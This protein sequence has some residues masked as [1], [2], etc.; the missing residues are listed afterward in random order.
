MMFL[1]IAIAVLLGCMMGVV[2]GITPGLHINLVAV[3]LLSASPFLLAYTNL[4]AVA[5]F[6]LAMY[7]THTFTDFI[8]ATYL[9]AP[10]DDT[11]MA[12]LPAHRMLLKGMA[13][14][15]IKLTVVG[16]LLCLIITILISRCLLF[17]VPVV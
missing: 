7:I 8:S 16:S 4:M 13:H 12:M 11:A 17:L 9:G 5:A 1:S 10:S 14:E 3:I 6:I 15:A 2:T